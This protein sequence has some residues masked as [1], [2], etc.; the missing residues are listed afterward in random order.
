MLTRRTALQSLG[1]G[2]GLGCIGDFGAF[3][4]AKRTLEVPLPAFTLAIHIPFVAAMREILPTVGAYEPAN[5]VR[6]DSLRVITQTVV[7]GSHDVADGDAITTLRATEAGADLKI[8]GLA[9]NSTSLVFVVNG[10]KIKSLTDLQ[11]PDTVVAVNSMGDFTHV[12]LIGPLLKRNVDLSKVTV[13]EIGGSG[14]RVRALLSGRVDAVPIH[15]DQAVALSQQGDYPIMIE[16]WK[17]Y[18]AWFGEVLFA[19]GAW[20]KKPE[21]ERAAIDLLKAT[22]I[23]YRR[24]DKDYDW[25]AAMYRKH[26]TIQ[27]A[28]K[29][30][31]ATLRPIWETLSKDVKAWPQQMET[32]TVANVQSLVPLYKRSQALEGSVKVD[33]VVDLRYLAQALKDPA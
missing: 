25:F 17:E 14:A 31:D 9:F 16:P 22:I 23:A 19:T 27:N 7:S 18:Q 8:I 12:M 26:S 6:F 28:A 29:T 33:Q 4:Q 20:L 24:A 5:L 13:V 2:A 11:R 3:A 15:F 32:L 30:T 1:A 21:N 10:K